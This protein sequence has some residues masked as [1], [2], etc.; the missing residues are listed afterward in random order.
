MATVPLFRVLDALVQNGKQYSE[1]HPLLEKQKT[2]GES[3]NISTTEECEKYHKAIDNCLDNNVVD[4]NTKPKFKVGDW[5]VFKNRHQSIYQVETIEDGYYILRHIH[6]GTVRLCV[7]HDEHLRLWTINDTEHQV[8]TFLE[9][10]KEYHHD[11]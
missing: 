10:K 1:E 8:D 7:L 2:V 3:L 4:N 9:L 6:G 11:A 5:V